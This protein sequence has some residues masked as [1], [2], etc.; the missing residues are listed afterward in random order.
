MSLSRNG[1]GNRIERRRQRDR[2][3]REAG[4]QKDVLSGNSSAGPPPGI[5]PCEAAGSAFSMVDRI[6]HA[7]RV[8][9]C[10]PRESRARRRAARL[11][12]TCRGVGGMR[13]W[14]ESRWWRTKQISPDAA[15]R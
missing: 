13:R 9:A 11:R 5:R 3:F 2:A 14:R 10:Y 7:H 1:T 8:R 12:F 6:V 15:G 4:E